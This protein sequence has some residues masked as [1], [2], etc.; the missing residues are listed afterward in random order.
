MNGPLRSRHRP[1][2]PGSLAE[3]IEMQRLGCE[4]AGSALYARVLAAVADDV[5]VGGPCARLLAPHAGR[6]FGDAVLLRLL[7]AVHLIV[8]EG[9]EP[10]L[11]AHYPSVDGTLGP[12]VGPRFI[13]AAEHHRDRVGELMLD[14]VQ[15]N[16]PGRSASLLGGYLEVA[17]LGIPLR[18][19]EVGASAG[20][21]LRFDHYR[22]EALGVAFGPADSPLCF[23]DPWFGQPPAL[24]RTVTVSSRKGC[25]LQP[26]DPTTEQ[27]RR[28]LR[29]YV[30]PDQT[31][32][33]IRLDGALAAAPRAEVTVDRADAVTWLGDRLAEAVPGVV[34]VVVHSVMF[35]Y[36]TSED[37][38]RFLGIIDL[39]GA[40]ASPDAPVAWLRMEPGGDQA[41]I[42]L[43]TWP[44]G[45]SLLVA[46]S[47][48][49]GPPVVPVRPAR[50][51][52]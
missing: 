42:R 14:C 27:D 48:Y 41:E 18:I 29:S 8:L 24:D 40:R 5:A 22:Y 50:L 52:D 17:E 25:D 4:L 33:R 45:G 1:P 7:A 49:H 37:R 39:A 32:R 13:A 36:L 3:T 38:R 34:T 35:Q 46:T 15:T 6:P 12:D 9:D 10:D 2:A 26:L 28:R 47:S 21:N 11:A 51:V 43:T 30:W 23:A 20:L 31:E 44:T 19:L 16:E